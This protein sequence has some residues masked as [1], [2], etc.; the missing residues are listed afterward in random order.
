[1]RHKIYNCDRI[2]GFR[3]VNVFSASYLR[4]GVETGLK[5]QGIFQFFMETFTS[6][7]NFLIA[8]RNQIKLRNEAVRP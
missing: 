1:M 8:H 5:R 2:T 7:S 3:Y 4:P 6:L